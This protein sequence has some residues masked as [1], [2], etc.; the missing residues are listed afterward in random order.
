[1]QARALAACDTKTMVSPNRH[2]NDTRS[3]VCPVVVTVA[4]QPGPPG[5]EGAVGA[6]GPPGPSG[7]AGEVGPPGPLGPAGTQ[8]ATG[9]VGAQGAVGPAGAPGPTGP[10]S[11]SVLFRAVTNAGFQVT[12]PTTATVPYAVQIYDL[13][14]GLPADNY[15]PATSVFTAP[16]DGVYRFEVP[17]FVGTIVPCNAVI[18]LVSD[19][20]APP[21]ERWVAFYDPTA[22]TDFFDA[23]LSGDFL[24]AAGQTVRVQATVPDGGVIGFSGL[25]HS[26]CGGLVSLAEPQ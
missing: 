2:K 24:L 18:A 1:M 9:A 6:G 5:A 8:G 13:Q 15:D 21:I 11:P 14:N 19:S 25:T 16:V 12:G 26:F 22:A 7:P 4:G 17:S 20:G 23:S 10:P 3:G